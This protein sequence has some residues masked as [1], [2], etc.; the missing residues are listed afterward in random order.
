M[1]PRKMKYCST[2]RPVE[3]VAWMVAARMSWSEAG[4]IITSIGLPIA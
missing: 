1:L 3:A 2:E 4:E